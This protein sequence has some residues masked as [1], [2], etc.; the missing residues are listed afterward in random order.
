MV[1]LVVLEKTNNMNVIIPMAGRGT[2]LRPQT[3]ITPKPLIEIAGKTI[4]QRIVELVTQKASK[5]IK[6]IGFIIEREDVE[7]EKT[8]QLIA[9]E[10]NLD[11]QIFYQGEAKGTAHAIYCARALLSG[12]TLIIFADTLF[13]ASFDFSLEAD[14]CILV[15]EVE[16]P[17]SYGVVQLN[18]DGHIV[19]FIE[20]PQDLISNLAIVGVY[21]FKE[22]SSLAN[23]IKNLLENNIMIKGEYQITTAL[24][25]LKNKNL[26]FTTHKINNWLDF[27]TSKNLLHSHAEILKKQSTDVGQFLNTTIHKP[28]YIAPTAKIEN[29][30]LGP[31][32]SVAEGSTI[33][34]SKIE[35]SIIQANSKILGATLRDS[36]IGRHVEYKEGFNKVNIGDYCRLNN[37]KDE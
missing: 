31:N 32:V 35:N 9:I 21:Y 27:G 37:D 29:S 18:K 28:C 20:K 23:E 26:K 13:D 12:P 11:F 33:K 15:K 2:R 30:I 8:L 1:D 4:I 25:N 6:K 5:R 7:I 24:Q 36:I 19:K 16:D 34:S 10:K 17:S 3:L 22:G 14:G